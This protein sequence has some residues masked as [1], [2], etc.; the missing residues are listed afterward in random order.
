MK[1]LAV[2][3]AA[4]GLFA[5]LALTVLAQGPLTLVDRDVML[6]LADHRTAWVT[7]LT[8]AMSAVHEV[9]LVLAAT[10]LV[11]AALAWRGRAHWAWLLLAVP[12]GTFA[13]RVL[14]HVFQ[15]EQ[16]SLIHI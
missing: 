9:P 3:L 10:A 4:L 12:T 8:L 7:T 11:A 16:L 15:R 13:N 2:A 1:R 14:K 5:L 6:F